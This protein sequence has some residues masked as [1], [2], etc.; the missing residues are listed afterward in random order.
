MKHP[1]S[2]RAW[3]KLNE[4]LTVTWS[5]VE[6]NG[7]LASPAVRV[8]VVD[9]VTFTTGFGTVVE[10]RPVAGDH[11]HVTPPA[12]VQPTAY[13]HGS[14]APLTQETLPSDAI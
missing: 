1:G 5:V 11:D 9:S 14:S 8:Y 12:F 7:K 4:G 13:S 10:P 2:V 6:Q 3:V